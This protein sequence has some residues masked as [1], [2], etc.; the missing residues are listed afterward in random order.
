M[1]DQVIA[2]KKVLLVD[3]DEVIRALMKLF[4]TGFGSF[5]YWEEGN[6]QGALNLARQIVPDIILVDLA[7]PVMD[8][9]QFTREIRKD[10]NEKLT[11]TPIIVI[12]GGGEEAKTLAYEAGAN[13]VLEKPLAK[14]L[15]I[16]ALRRVLIV[17]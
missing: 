16:T 5:E 11:K 14:K 13:M 7:M 3:D 1:T 4:L 8:G 10:S 9:T 17:K 2:T 6:G 12:T 15:L